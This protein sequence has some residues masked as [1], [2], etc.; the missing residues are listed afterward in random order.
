MPH[1]RVL[2][3]DEFTDEQEREAIRLHSDARRHG[4]TGELPEWVILARRQYHRHHNRKYKIDRPPGS[5][6]SAVI[7]ALE[8]DNIIDPD[9]T[10]IIDWTAIEIAVKG[11]RVV[12]MTR[13]E[14]VLAVAWLLEHSD[15][16]YLLIGARIGMSQISTIVRDIRERDMHKDL[17]AA[18]EAG[19]LD[20][21]GSALKF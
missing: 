3:A 10:E 9:A 19:D 18:I 1:D 7:P 8:P 15:L 2:M 13:N 17:L 14:R 4:K 6:E 20:A 21:S 12:N 5:V 11:V 16:S